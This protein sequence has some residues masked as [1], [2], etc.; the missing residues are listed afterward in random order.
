VLRP[1][2]KLAEG[3]RYYL[4]IK[5]DPVTYTDAYGAQEVVDHNLE[6]CS[7]GITVDTTPPTLVDLFCL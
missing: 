1:S 3:R 7:D 5:A 4:C 6:L 2:S